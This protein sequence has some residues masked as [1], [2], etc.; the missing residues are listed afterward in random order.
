MEEY[1]E[2]HPEE[3][4]DN[5]EYD[6][7][8]NIIWTWK[9]VIDPLPKMDHSTVKYED[10]K[11]D[12]YNEHEQIL[13]L[14]AKEVFD[15]RN[16]LDIRVF[17]LA[18]PKPCTSFAHFNLEES[19]MNRIRKAN[20]ET[21]TP[22]QAQGIPVALL[23]RDLLGLAKTVSTIF[24]IHCNSCFK[25]KNNFAS[26]KWQ[27]VS[28]RSSSSHS[29][30]GTVIPKVIQERSHCCRYCPHQRTRSSSI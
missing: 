16:S 21:P 8:G 4:E 12:F 13:G 17:G 3:D 27:N 5:Y 30:F 1:K 22:I 19:L 28:V 11:A 18:P 25:N 20:F 6:E 9:K 14:T 26:G 29:R 10:F 23:G 15:L 2:R 7:D 24:I